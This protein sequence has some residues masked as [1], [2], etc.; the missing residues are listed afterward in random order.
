MQVEV[1]SAASGESLLFLRGP[2]VRALTAQQVKITIART[3]QSVC[4]FR[5][6]LLFR[7]RILG[8][9]EIPFHEESSSRS[10]LECVFLD[11]Q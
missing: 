4:R 8:E 1:R 11:K 9:E 10:P 3:L 2:Y 6:K 5:I 7:G